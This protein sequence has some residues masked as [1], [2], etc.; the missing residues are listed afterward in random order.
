MVDWIVTA[1]VVSAIFAGNALLLIVF[2]WRTDPY[3][4]ATWMR[5]LREK[6]EQWQASRP[7]PKL[8]RAVRKIE[9]RLP[10]NPFGRLFTRTV[11]RVPTPARMRP[12][13]ADERATARLEYWLALENLERRSPT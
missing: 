1:L 13:A 8:D 7:K 12:A 4:F 11:R 10:A 6:R 9:W 2:L 3:Q 5:A